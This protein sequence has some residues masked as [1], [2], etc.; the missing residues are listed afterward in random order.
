M[1][2]SLFFILSI[3]LFLISF[4]SCGYKRGHGTISDAYSTVAVPYIEG[5]MEGALTAELIRQ[6]GQ[7]GAFEYS[8]SS[9]DLTLNV[10]I[11]DHHEEFIGYDFDVDSAGTPV[12]RLVPTEARYSV[13]TEVTLI[14]NV[15]GKALVGPRRFSSSVDYDFDPDITRSNVTSFSLGQL[16]AKDAAEDAAMKPLGASLAKNIIDHIANSW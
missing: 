10:K 8:D 11:I 6:L 2:Y 13:L 14:E 1:R 4:T 16:N 7:S 15:S 3:P 5:D 9:S 12:R